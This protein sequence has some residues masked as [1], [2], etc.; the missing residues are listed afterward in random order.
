MDHQ[1]FRRVD[2]GKRLEKCVLGHEQVSLPELLIEQGAVFREILSQETW[3]K[4]L[5]DEQRQHLSQFLPDFPKGS[6]EDKEETLRMLFGGENFKFGNP[7]KQFQMKL[8]E[9]FFAPD[10]A[11]YSALCRKGKKREYKIRQQRYYAKLL[12]EILLARQLVLEEVRHLPPDE[13]PKF[14]YTPPPRDNSLENRVK[15]KYIKILK[16]VREECE[17]EDT[18]SE[19]DLPPEKAPAPRHKKGAVKSLY[20]L[21]SPDHPPPSV[22]STFASKPLTNGDVIT[23]ATVGN[24]NAPKAKVRVSSPVDFTDDD[25][26]H[27]LRTHKRRRTEDLDCPDMDTQ[28][29]MLQDI[30]FRCQAIRKAPAKS[31]ISPSLT[32]GVKKRVKARERPE[33]K[34]KR[35]RPLK[36]VVKTEEDSMGSKP[37]LRTEEDSQLTERDKLLSV[38]RDEEEDSVSDFPLQESQAPHLLFGQYS[39][40]FSLLR[41]LINEFDD[42]KV[43]TAKMEEKVREWQESS[44]CSLNPWF[45]QQPNWVDAVV[46]ALKFL[47]GDALGL[48]LENFIPF[49]D[50]KERAQQWKWIGASRDTDAQLLPLFKHW[51]E[52]KDDNPSDF[53]D[54]SQ[55]SPPP[56]RIKTNF[57]VR[58]T[59]QEEKDIFK[60]QERRRFENPHKA[61]TYVLHGYES[62]VGPVKGVYSKDNAMNKAREHNLLISDRPSYVTILTLV[63]DAA[64]RLPNGEGTRGDI[65]ELLKDSGFIAPG[66]TD[67]QINTVVSGALDR[68]HYE[69]DPCVKYEVNRKL[70]VYL[71]RNRTEEEFEKIHQAQGAAVKAKKSLQK[72]KASRSKSKD[73]S[74]GTTTPAPQ[75]ASVG[76]VSKTSTANHST[77]SEESSIASLLTPTT[78]STG[79]SPG[80]NKTSGSPRGHAA[81]QTTS[82]NAQKTPTARRAV[83]G[84]V[85]PSGTLLQASHQVGVVTSAAISPLRGSPQVVTTH[86]VTQAGKAVSASVKPA[87]P[88]SKPVTISFMQPQSGST[89]VP[90]MT[91]VKSGKTSHGQ[92]SFNLLQTQDIS[93]KLTATPSLTQVPSPGSLVLTKSAETGTPRA[94]KLPTSSASSLTVTKSASPL[95]GTPAASSSVSGTPPAS[96]SSPVVARLVQQVPHPQMM[97]VGNLLQGTVQKMAGRGSGPTTIKIQVTNSDSTSG[98]ILSSALQGGSVVS[99]TK[100]GATVLQ[101]QNLQV[102]SQ[103]RVVSP[104]QAGIVVTQLAPGSLS[105]RPGLQNLSQAKLLNQS[106]VLPTQ[107]IV[108]QAPASFKGE[109]VTTATVS[110]GGS[111][112]TPI[113]V[114]APGGK[115]GQNIQL[116]K[117]V[118]SQ[119]AGL[120]PGQATILISQPNIPQSATSTV[121]SN[122]HLLQAATKVTKA[123]PKGKPQPV[124][125]RIITPP[126]GMRLANV[127]ASGQT[128]SA[129]G[130]SVIQTM[131]KLPTGAVVTATAQPGG[132][133]KVTDSPAAKS[134]AP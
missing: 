4:E 30:M 42:A 55:G 72:P 14:I 15:K 98:T 129:P 22:V 60:E 68:L 41:D 100:A 54:S 61:F 38:S 52:N 50:Y 118:L 89:T 110:Q 114:S 130:V 106:G 32:V 40:F 127:S 128:M 82:P 47:S 84:S 111:L 24:E 19:E 6:E 7:L 37:S 108:Q 35:E 117:T 34:L 75:T 74:G 39:N 9:G 96:S 43:T 66:V 64:A 95:A 33:R 102:V 62:V 104:S 116:V 93:G 125:A 112:S 86:Q 45:S 131:G 56:N 109:G 58:P 92:L 67:A 46:S 90:V 76:S 21:P 18:S 73:G 48:D 120:K 36:E 20:P 79:V 1:T 44:T 101:S 23:P 121:S 26:V 17:V 126:P 27:M 3:S 115:P 5:T 71:H 105:L 103:P 2:A 57:V 69:K 10:I 88:G 13:T 77:A 49:L 25:Y 132:L 28:N 97:S 107:F 99:H 31:P 59:T 87:T 113:I 8:R 85:I 119:H 133:T 29:I 83:T 16:E 63:R 122:T 81:K 123:S 94:Q 65:C 134:P 124:Y 51:L 80:P 91:Q 70:W 78:A 12:Q 53:F 11:K